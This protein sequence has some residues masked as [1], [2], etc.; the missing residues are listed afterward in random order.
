MHNPCHNAKL[1]PAN[2]RHSSIVI[3][4]DPAV[5]PGPH[6]T[7]PVELVVYPREPHGIRERRHQ[8]D[9]MDRV[10]EFFGRWLRV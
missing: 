9:L 7:Q 8:V 2:N 10:R 4:H 1:A 6:P 3:R 5:E